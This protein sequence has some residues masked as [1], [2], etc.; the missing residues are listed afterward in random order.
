MRS[1]TAEGP[2]PQRLLPTDG[3][4]AGSNMAGPA[5]QNHFPGCAGERNRDALVLPRPKLDSPPGDSAGSQVSGMMVRVIRFQSSLKWKGIT[6]WMLSTSWVPSKGPTPKFVL[7]WNG[8]LMRSATGFCSFFAR[9]VL[10]S[11][12]LLSGPAVVPGEPVWARENRGKRK[13][14]RRATNRTGAI[15]DCRNRPGRRS[16]H[17][18]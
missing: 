16:R 3:F 10:L 2:A 5:P 7:L 17:P 12:W 9:S 15:V 6:G 4:V 13:Q 18:L 11:L 1:T 8:T 14:R